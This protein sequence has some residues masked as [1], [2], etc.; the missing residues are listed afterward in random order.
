M[1]KELGLIQEYTILYY[2]K[3]CWV[4]IIMLDW[5]NYFFV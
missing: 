1:G 2:M 3:F 4:G 5:G